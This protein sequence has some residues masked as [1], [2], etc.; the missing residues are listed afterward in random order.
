MKHDTL[1]SLEEE[2]VTFD[3]AA[4]LSGISFKLRAGEHWR[5]RGG[6]GSGKTTFLRLL[7][8]ELN[9]DKGIGPSR[10]WNFD[11]EQSSSP[12]MG[13]RNVALVTP[14][15]QDLYKRRGWN[16]TGFECIATGLRDTPLLYEELSAE[17]TAVVG[18]VIADTH[19][20]A[21]R[22]KSMLEMSRGETRKIFIARSI[23][24]K[25][26][27]L[28][29]DELL[30][31]LD[32]SSREEIVRITESA[33]A[34]GITIVYTSH[35]EDELLPCTKRSALIKNGILTVDET[36]SQLAQYTAKPPHPSLVTPP[37]RRDAEELVAMRGCSVHIEETKVL[38]SITFSARKGIHTVI[39]GK[40]G[41]GKS[42]LLRT[43]YGYLSPALGGEIT[44]FGRTSPCPLAPSQA[45]MGY[46]SAE[47]QTQCDPEDTLMDI[48]LSGFFSSVGMR[49]ETTPKQNERAMELLA[50]FGL[51]GRPGKLYGDLSY[52]QQRKAILSRALA[53]SPEL[54][55]LDEPMSGLDPDSRATLEDL[56]EEAAQ[57][58]STI[59][60][61]VH[62][63]EDIPSF[64]KRI[65][66]LENGRIISS[67]E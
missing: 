31:E 10:I 29:L 36:I 51:D 63:A 26:K 28:L 34:R 43:L 53:H 48:V 41:A 50:R 40:N 65:I 12:I 55:L 59:V 52:G 47:L 5:I 13:K 57:R 1:I 56:L 61:A 42:T 15:T 22:D 20:E 9:S 32:P 7:R 46:A 44:R 24:A 38:D 18:Q 66:A 33:A 45:R 25:P 17:E 3:D 27:V 39:A 54:I 11:G 64:A 30:H 4:V 67:G 35:R 19:T 14:T 16:I 60:M 21:L 8:G 2:S 62:H 6:N 58:G 23:A 37:S 49:G